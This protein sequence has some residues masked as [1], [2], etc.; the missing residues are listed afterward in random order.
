VLP[1]GV[2]TA[3][4]LG[5][6]VLVVLWEF[7]GGLLLLVPRFQGPLLAFSWT[8]HATLSLIG[9]VNFGS[10]AL[11]LL[12][13]FLP[14]RYVALLQRPVRLPVIG[15]AVPRAALYFALN[16][17]TGIVAA[18]DRRHVAAV[19]FNLTVLLFLWPILRDV[20]AQL[21]RPAWPGVSPWSRSTPRWLYVFP[22][23]LL[24]HG[25]TPY[26]GLRTAG[27]FSMFSNLRTE[28]ERSNHLLLRGN[29]LK[30]WGY[31]EDMVRITEVDD[32]PVALNDKYH[33]TASDNLP[34]KGQQLPVVEFRK[35]IYAWTNAGRAIPLTLEY[36]G[37]SHTTADIVTDP[38]WRTGRRDWEMRLMDFRIV[39]PDGPNQCRW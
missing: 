29:P 13:T 37:Q 6:A 14:P 31:Q 22:V 32:S 28:G 4:L 25:L 38:V 36:R 17:I 34:Q 15:R 35:W 23:L 26:L 1:A 21:P 8:M 18:L 7:A 24:L 16:G 11:A 33:T 27:N 20:V 10:L 12:F 19:P 3:A 30:I 9:L 5:M 2:T 39:Q